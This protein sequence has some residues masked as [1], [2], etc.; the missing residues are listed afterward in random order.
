MDK[1]TWS[2][3]VVAD[4]LQPF[5]LVR[6]DADAGATM[7]A[8]AI[9]S[10]RGLVIFDPGEQPRF[11][12]AGYQAPDA[13]VQQLHRVSAASK[14]LIGASEAFASGDR[15]QAWMH[16]G[17][18]YSAASQSASASK[19]YATA[20]TEAGARGDTKTRLIAE[21][22]CATMTA[23]DDPAEA[24]KQL[25]KVEPSDINEVEFTRQMAFAMAHMR[26]GDRKA[27]Q[28]A[29]LKALKHCPDEMKEQCEAEGREMLAH[30][31]IARPPVSP[32][33]APSA[34]E[35]KLRP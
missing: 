29:Y 5:L 15:V 24:I 14:P 32:A 7:G 25:R 23:A 26:R 28:W 4:S 17:A 6:V 35:R 21:I 18:A 33:T 22:Y 19:A 10:F 12:F 9:G 34:E 1:V 16:L 8:Y 11:R 3:P 31:T 20:A 13:L 2:D 27:G 30:R